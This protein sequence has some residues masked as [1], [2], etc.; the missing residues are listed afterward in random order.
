MESEDRDN[1][2]IDA[3]GWGCIGVI[4]HSTDIPRINFNNQ[5][6]DPDYEDFICAE[7]AE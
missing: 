7:S 6:S 5:V 2:A 1:P 3:S 4:Q